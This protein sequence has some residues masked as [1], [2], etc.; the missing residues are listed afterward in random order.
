MYEKLKD[1][2]LKK[3][4]TQE[5]MAVKLGYKY[6]SGYNQLEKGKRKIDI[7][8]ARKISLI[9]EASIEEIFFDKEVVNVNTCDNKELSE[10]KKTMDETRDKLNELAAVEQNHQNEE[11]LDLS[12]KLDN[13][14]YR[15]MTLERD[16]KLKA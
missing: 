11:V 16:L 1:L 3:G 2:R 13:L 8:T 15:Y 4:I 5:E 9:L 12:R 10:L 6:T 7:E 14:I